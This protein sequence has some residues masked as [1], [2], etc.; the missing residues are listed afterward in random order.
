MTINYSQEMNSSGKPTFIK[1]LED[2]A[3]Q[4]HCEVTSKPVSAWTR[5][6]KHVRLC[7]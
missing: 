6:Y 5:I 3:A 4:E 1:T 7:T 2:A